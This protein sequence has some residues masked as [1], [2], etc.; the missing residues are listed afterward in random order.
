[1][2]R[3]A[4]EKD[5]E[6]LLAIYAPYIT[7]TAITFEYETPS[8]EEFRERIRSTLQKYPYLV[9]AEG[10]RPLGYAYAGPFSRRKAGDWAVE[11]SIYLERDQRRHGYGALL[12]EALEKELRRQ[13]ICSMCAC[14]AAPRGSDPYLST[15]SLSFHARLGYR[16]VG[17]FDRVGYKFDRWY[18]L[19]WMQKEIGDFTIPAPVRRSFPETE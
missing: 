11:T 18:D 12:H 19:V 17:R 2:I 3:T 4:T 6:A 16:M 9:I 13:G 7:E 1:M 14:I 5:A 10:G 15:D 8:C